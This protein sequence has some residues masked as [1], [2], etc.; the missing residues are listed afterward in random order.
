M[1]F[2]A[3]PNIGA[4]DDFEEWLV[5]ASWN[6]HQ[7]SDPIAQKF[8]SAIELRL[9]EFDSD[10]VQEAQLK[11]QLNELLRDFSIGISLGP[12]TIDSGSSMDFSSQQWTFSPADRRLSG[13]YALPAH[14]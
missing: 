12:R 4:L 8:I 7:H 9:A 3:S 14:R 2:L 11:K 1:D 13:A 6:M 5:G 10:K